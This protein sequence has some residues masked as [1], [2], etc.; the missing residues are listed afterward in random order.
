MRII[1]EFHDWSRHLKDPGHLKKSIYLILLFCIFST[2]RS[3]APLQRSLSNCPIIVSNLFAHPGQSVR[4]DRRGLIWVALMPMCWC[5][6]IIE[7]S[8]KKHVPTL[9]WWSHHGLDLNIFS[10]EK[11]QRILS[12]NW[13]QLCAHKRYWFGRLIWHLGREQLFYFTRPW[14]MLSTFHLRGAMQK[15]T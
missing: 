8:G 3:M 11:T 15:W 6:F 14:I 12:L 2:Q 9:I 13:R 4:S 1:K 10:A 7:L 5:W